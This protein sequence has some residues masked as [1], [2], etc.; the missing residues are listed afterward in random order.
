MHFLEFLQLPRHHAFIAVGPD[1]A[2]IPVVEPGDIGAVGAIVAI[3]FAE[4]DLLRRLFRDRLLRIGKV[5]V[6]VVADRADGEAAR[7]VAERLRGY[8]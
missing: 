1:P 6:I 7:T 5:R 3:A 2:P 4:R 8:G